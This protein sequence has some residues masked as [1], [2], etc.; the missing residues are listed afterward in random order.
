MLSDEFP[1]QFWGDRAGGFMDPFGYRWSVA[2]HIKDLSR[3]E[4]EEAAKAAGM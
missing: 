2:T 3:K 4:M 1:D